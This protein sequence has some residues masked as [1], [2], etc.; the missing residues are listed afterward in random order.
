VLLLRCSLGLWCYALRLLRDA[1]SV[2]L[3]Y[4]THEWDRVKPTTVLLRPDEIES[5]AAMDSETFQAQ[6]EPVW[7]QQR[8][9]QAAGSEEIEESFDVVRRVPE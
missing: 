9:A 2:G 1:C 3:Y 7:Q 6:A 8:E 4:R 5:A